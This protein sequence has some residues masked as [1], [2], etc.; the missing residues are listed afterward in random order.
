[1]D[2]V[3]LV[4]DLCKKNKAGL[5][6][7]FFRVI[8]VM[9]L[10]FCSDFWSRMA[11]KSWMTLVLHGIW[12]MFWRIDR[13]LL[14]KK[15]RSR[16]VLGRHGELRAV[17]RSSVFVLRKA[18]LDVAIDVAG[19]TFEMIQHEKSIQT[20]LLHIRLLMRCMIRLQTNES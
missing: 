10:S 18:D 4:G 15:Q 20:V 7:R 6:D 9:C 12:A 3:L 5:I 16:W 13:K 1:M 2:V 19:F 11:R 14:K 17:Q 8:G